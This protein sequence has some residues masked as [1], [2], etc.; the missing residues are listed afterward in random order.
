MPESTS[1][2]RIIDRIDQIKLRSL[3][4]SSTG[5][6]RVE[7]IADLQEDAS[8][9]LNLAVEM[10]NVYVTNGAEG[11]SDDDLDDHALEDA[12]NQRPNKESPEPPLSGDFES[13]MVEVARGHWDSFKTRYEKLIGSCSTLLRE[14]QR[15]IEYIQRKTQQSGRDQDTN[16]FEE[17]VTAAER[18]TDV[19][20]DLA[21]YQKSFG[22]A[23]N[24]YRYFRRGYKLDPAE[25]P[26]LKG[27]IEIWVLV[28]II[29][30]LETGVNG[31]FYAQAS[32]SG[33]IGGWVIAALVS[34]VIYALAYVSGLSLRIKNE[35]VEVRVTSD[36]QS[37][38]HG[39]ESVAKSQGWFSG[40]K[41]ILLPIVA[42]VFC[43]VLAQIAFYVS[44]SMF[45]TSRFTSAV[46]ALATFFISIIAY[47]V[48]SITVTSPD[49]TYEEQTK[50]N[51]SIQTRYETRI[52]KKLLG[53]VLFAFLTLL[54]VCFIFFIG[55]YRDEAVQQDAGVSELILMTLTYDR[56]SDFAWMPEAD[57]NGFILLL[58]NFFICAFVIFKGY[59]DWETIPG[60]RVKALNLKKSRIDYKLRIEFI[61]DRIKKDT[62]HD[63]GVA[64]V[65]IPDVLTLIGDYERLYEERQNLCE[66]FS[67]LIEVSK[68]NLANKISVY[69]NL[70]KDHRL[71]MQKEELP[72][73]YK[74]EPQSNL[75]PIKL[76]VAQDLE[77]RC[78][79]DDQEE[80]VDRLIRHKERAIELI[81]TSQQ[82]KISDSLAQYEKEPDNHLIEMTREDY[83][84]E[85]RE[86]RDERF[87]FWAD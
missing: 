37:H 87:E 75:T 55:I 17:Q 7:R 23:F 2:S 6:S 71:E 10:T 21:S 84:D 67:A 14:Y 76:T 74:E 5:V 51:Q 77:E 3:A 86:E 41:R 1:S 18:S 73:W 40:I 19:A 39:G 83:E 45:E 63:S 13:S 72:H 26:K 8:E 27:M 48:V 53:W 34:I 49:D 28:F 47:A 65:R 15:Q 36:A 11:F 81:N 59:H 82:Q 70:N 44:E 4:S 56:F 68:D 31:T 58:A 61:R 46:I 43:L 50:L 80:L 25:F 38:A 32:P 16:Y 66:R 29:I 78:E 62:S 57:I 30:V 33:L 85:W 79:F 60:H 12:S 20:N 24:H 22:D 42:L 52:D 9:A 69:R 64:E 54:V 35:L